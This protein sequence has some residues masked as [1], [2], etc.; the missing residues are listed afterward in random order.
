MSHP[1]NARPRVLLFAAL[2]GLAASGLAR[3]DE[4]CLDWRWIAVATAA[5]TSCTVPE[6]SGWRGRALF[7]DDALARSR[8]LRRFCS[9]EPLAASADAARLRA[10][11]GDRY[12]RIDRDCAAAGGHGASGTTSVHWVALAQE[13][14]RQSGFDGVPATDLLGPHRV[15]LTVVDSNPTNAVDPARDLGR[16]PHGNALLTLAESLACPS[17]APCSV[18]VTSQLGLRFVH[19]D[20]ARRDPAHQDARQGGLLGSIADVATAIDAELADWRART[21]DHR[22]VVNLSLGWA[23][24]LGG[25]QARAQ[26]MPVRAQAVLAVLQDASCDGVLVFAAA[27]NR[28]AGIDEEAGPLYPAAWETRAAPDAAGC[29]RLRGHG[30]SADPRAFA[31]AYRPLVHAVGGIEADGTP[32]D[33]ARP[34]SVPRL[35]AYADHA[36]AESLALGPPPS[37]LPTA[38]LTGSSV[39]SLLAALNAAVAWSWDPSRGAHE[40][41][42]LLHAA[43]IGTPSALGR[44]VDVCLRDAAGRCVDG[45]ADVHRL[46]AC[47]TRRASG[48]AIPGLACTWMASDPRLGV[49][50]ADFDAAATPIDLSSQVP[51]GGDPACGAAVLHVDPAAVLPAAPC[52]HLALLG[53]ASR[54][55][56]M[57]QPGSDVC[58]HCE[59]TDETLARIAAKR[60]PAAARVLRI[61]IAP[62]LSRPVDTMAL[63]VGDR[64]FVLAPAQPIRGGDRYLVRGLAAQGLGAAELEHAF[65]AFGIDG[66]YAAVSP[67]FHED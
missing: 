27:G 12:T 50:R 35:A 23:A 30:G 41:A 64:V 8:D 21:P 13:L 44:R 28:E 58:P 62:R 3:A 24:A 2:A 15:R 4:S 53:V 10:A 61:E 48:P 39:A 59:D 42:S 49:D 7:S 46:D 55:W 16:S 52:P 65:V 51:I 5:D 17:G 36:V 22:L 1:A 19:V 54:P 20:P 60:V 31:G 57:P 33:N 63:V 45:I 43:A 37:G 11:T 26:D 14:R 56:V 47:L 18:D 9:F 67:L 32:I 66:R 40:V 34:R 29:A 6:S 25:A 38:T